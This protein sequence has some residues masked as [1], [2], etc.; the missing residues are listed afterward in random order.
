MKKDIKP[1]EMRYVVRYAGSLAADDY[2]PLARNIVESLARL[3]EV[4]HVW[5]KDVR[6]SDF[7]EGTD[8]LSDL[9]TN[10][11]LVYLRAQQHPT[12]SRTQ[13]HQIVDEVFPDHYL[14][15][16][17]TVDKIAQHLLTRLPFPL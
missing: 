14:G 12:I 9:Y 17:V 1:W 5:A 8:T 13:F 2:R 11:D 4:E 16:P 7:L 15:A 6:I 10:T 3:K